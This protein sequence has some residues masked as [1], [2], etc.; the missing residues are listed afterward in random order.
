MKIV[1]IQAEKRV[2]DGKKG[3]KAIRKAGMVPCVLYGGEEAISFQ[4]LAKSFKNVVYSPDFKIIELEI[5]GAKHKCILK[6]LQFHPV[7]DQLLHVDLLRIIDGHPIKVEIPIRTKGVSPGEI[8][9]GK[10]QVYMRKVKVKTKPEFLVDELNVDISEMK[11]GQSVRVRDIE[12]PEGIEV[13]S[14]MGTPVASI[15]IPRVLKSLD[16]EEAL[17]VEAGEGAEVETVEE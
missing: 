10:L 3:A 2:A 15:E 7:T 8:L 9:G 17:D 6:D 14:V 4:A 12:V 13:M 1:T 5:D 16:E 11:L